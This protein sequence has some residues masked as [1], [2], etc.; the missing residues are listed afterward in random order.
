MNIA[1]NTDTDAFFFFFYVRCVSLALSKTDGCA[2]NYSFIFQIL[3][4]SQSEVNKFSVLYK[5]K[6]K[7]FV[8]IIIGTCSSRS[9]Y[10]ILGLVTGLMYAL[11]AVSWYNFSPPP[12]PGNLP[13][14]HSTQIVTFPHSS[15]GE[16]ELWKHK[17]S[18]LNR[19]FAKTLKIC[20]SSPPWLSVLPFC[21]K[22]FMR[23]RRLCC[24]K[25]FMHSSFAASLAAGRAC[26]FVW[27]F[28]L[29]IFVERIA[30]PPSPLCVWQ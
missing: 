17:L 14:R 10:F 11:S 9:Y 24:P 3:N 8:R 13:N 30:P 19:I 25:S 15:L 6:K 18:S 7:E 5:K 28:A 4:R 12:P 20:T 16:V 2:F 27:L 22:D 23:W 26:H 29:C 1:D 21:I